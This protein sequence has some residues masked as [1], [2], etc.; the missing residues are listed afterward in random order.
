MFWNSQFF[1]FIYETKIN[2]KAYD[3]G[4]WNISYFKINGGNIPGI[5]YISQ[6]LL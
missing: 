5:R 1:G 4:V 3:L 2:V 6:S